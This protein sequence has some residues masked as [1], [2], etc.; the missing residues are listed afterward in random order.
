MEV[1]SVGSMRYLISLVDG[2]IV[3]FSL[4]IGSGYVIGGMGKASKN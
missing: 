2:Q 3:A 1:G 4:L